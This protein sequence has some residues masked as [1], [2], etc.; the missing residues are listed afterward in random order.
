MSSLKYLL[1]HIYL[2]SKWQN[3]YFSLPYYCISPFKNII[4]VWHKSKQKKLRKCNSDSK[5]K[6]WGENHKYSDLKV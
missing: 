3:I 4:T 2:S 1:D 6:K 5:G